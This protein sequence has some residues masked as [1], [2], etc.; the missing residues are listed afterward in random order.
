[1]ALYSVS[2][3]V[4]LM[5][6]CPIAT[7]ARLLGIHP[8]TLHHWLD[9]AQ[10]P[11][12]PHPT[13]ARIKCVAEEHLRE[14]ARQHGRPFP[15]LTDAPRLSAR[16]PLPL[17]EETATHLSAHEADPASP[18]PATSVPSAPEA[19]L[20]QRLAD[21]ET[22]ISTL[23]E[24]LAG[25]ALALLQERERTV[26]RRITALEA[27]I[28]ALMHKHLPPDLLELGGS[29]EPVGVSPRVHQLLPVDRKSTRLNSSHIPLFRMP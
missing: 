26:E 4:L 14:V 8:K 9:D 2:K 24:Q 19:G 25:L 5:T 16:S 1:M 28:P 6:P 17:H 22:K 10:V 13:D 20:I 29:Q 21:L 11:L 23:P 3:G 27:L 18:A 7:G 12:V 15:P